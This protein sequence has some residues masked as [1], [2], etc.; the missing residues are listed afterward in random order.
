MYD[1][2]ARESAL[3]TD[4]GF[5]ALVAQQDHLL[6]FDTGGDG[7]I[8]L[9]NLASLKIDPHRI[10]RVVLSHA[11]SDHTGGLNALLATDTQPTVSLLP[12]FPDSVK[13][14]LRRTTQ[15]V[16]VSRGQILG[17]GIFTTGEVK[18]T[19]SEQ[20]L[21]I[22][23]APG[24]VI[25]TGCAHPGVTTMVAAAQAVHDAPI[26]LLVGGFHLGAH[27][28]VEIATVLAELRRLGVQ[29]VAPCHCT[30]ERATAAF[31]EEYGSNFISLGVGRLI[32][33][34]QALQKKPLLRQ[35]A[36]PPYLN[37]PKDN[38]GS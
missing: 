33:V 31:A 11:H 20:A 30:G 34:E 19:I 26:H 23:A 6:L 38:T 13:Q 2:V 7:Q 21:V 24:L 9:E 14:S 28:E 12:S 15:V 35:N 32:T 3:Q 27:S 25:L 29:Q 16:E 17:E 37:T 10:E 1:N 18:G 22:K 5:A 36:Y 8:L 4:W